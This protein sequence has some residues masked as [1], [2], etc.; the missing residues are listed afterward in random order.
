MKMV[1]VVYSAAA[2]YD[3]L[4]KLKEHGISG[5]TKLQKAC[6]E[7]TET[8]PKLKTHTWPGDNNLLLIATGD[9][10]ANQIINILAG[11]KKIHPRAGVRGF[12]IPLIETI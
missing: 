7:G 11:L 2:D 6:G 5:Y 10:D 3:I 9:E 1:M 8:E 4:N 12:V